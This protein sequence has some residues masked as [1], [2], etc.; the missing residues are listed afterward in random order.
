[1]QCAKQR[2]DLALFSLSSRAAL[3]MTLPQRCQSLYFLNLAM[4]DVSIALDCVDYTQV[5]DR[6][7]VMD[8]ANVMLDSVSASGAQKTLEAAV[9]HGLKL[10]ADLRDIGG[11]SYRS[12][13]RLDCRAPIGRSTW[14]R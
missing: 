6:Q 11:E 10:A 7:R 9:A 13:V 3:G 2:V 4:L 12:R 5:L 1:M 14:C 8:I